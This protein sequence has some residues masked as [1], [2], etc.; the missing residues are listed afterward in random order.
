MPR[1]ELVSVVTFDSKRSNRNREV[2]PNE[3]ISPPPQ[4]HQLPLPSF[5]P[6][7]IALPTH[8]ESDLLAPLPKPPWY[9]RHSFTIFAVVAI[10]C[11]QGR[12]F[13]DQQGVV[14]TTALVVHTESVVAKAALALSKVAVWGEGVCVYTSAERQ[15]CTSMLHSAH[16]YAHS[17]YFAVQPEFDVQRI[18]RRLH[19]AV[20]KIA[21]NLTADL[22][23]RTTELI[24]RH[25]LAPVL[26]S[27]LRLTKPHSESDDMDEDIGNLVE[28]VLAYIEERV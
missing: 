9:K 16:E 19:L 22:V 3:D 25:A 20:T 21:A 17:R 2:V 5:T 18:G 1:N 12:A 24:L 14:N 13:L 8:T 15:N 6:P 4:E 23:G 27:L 7:P 11:Y 10:V 26:T 28:D